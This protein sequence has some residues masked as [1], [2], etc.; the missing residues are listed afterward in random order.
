MQW[1][2]PAAAARR[3]CRCRRA[4]AAAAP[5]FC[6][7]P[8]APTLPPCSMGSSAH[9]TADAVAVCRLRFPTGTAAAS[10]VVDPLPIQRSPAHFAGRQPLLPLSQCWLWVGASQVPRSPHKRRAA[11]RPRPPACSQL[12]TLQPAALCI[13]MHMAV[14]T[15]HHSSPGHTRPAR[16]PQSLAH[17]A[18]DRRLCRPAAAPRPAQEGAR[19]G[20]RS[21]QDGPGVGPRLSW[22]A[23]SGPLFPHGVAPRGAVVMQRR[24]WRPP[25]DQ[26]FR[27]PGPPHVSCR[28]FATPAA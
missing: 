5:N 26:P 1:A 19:A 21:G 4:H 14:H 25:Y 28:L 18:T 7:A 9:D 16:S 12:P 3:F 13:R 23:P 6:T 8:P 24:P 17:P 27:R 10:C 22:A 2:A 20:V 11:A 15:P